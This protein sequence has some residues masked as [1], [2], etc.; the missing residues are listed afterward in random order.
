MIQY[1][2]DLSICT[3]HRSIEVDNCFELCDLSLMFDDSGSDD[4]FMRRPLCL[5]LDFV[6]LNTVPVELEIWF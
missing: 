2:Y 1:S 3:C 6:D 5:I 4:W